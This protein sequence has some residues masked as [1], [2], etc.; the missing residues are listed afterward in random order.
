MARSKNKHQYILS[1]KFKL[2]KEKLHRTG[3]GVICCVDGLQ[4][5]SALLSSIQCNCSFVATSKRHNE[6]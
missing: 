5:A 2:F 3:E 4:E 6:E 1:P